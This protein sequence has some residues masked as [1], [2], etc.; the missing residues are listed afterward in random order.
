MFKSVLI[1][2]VVVSVVML[3]AL[4]AGFPVFASDGDSPG[5]TAVV[6]ESSGLLGEALD[7]LLDLFGGASDPAGAETDGHP[8]A[9]PAG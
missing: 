8:T 1:R 6:T 3:C 7:W 2:R 4:G 9:D 5:E